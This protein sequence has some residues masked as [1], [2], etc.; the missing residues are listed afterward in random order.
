MKNKKSIFLL[1]S[2]L[3]VFCF[4]S[5]AAE[6]KPKFKNIISVDSNHVFFDFSNI[7]KDWVIVTNQT[8]KLI[9]V[10]Y[11]E[12]DEN[13]TIVPPKKYNFMY[14]FHS[15]LQNQDS[16]EGYNKGKC[17]LE[18]V[19]GNLLQYAI[20]EKKNGIVI[21]CLDFEQKEVS[22][23]PKEID[24]WTIDMLFD[25]EYK[26]KFA[27]EEKYT[28]KVHFAYD[29]YEDSIQIQ[30]D[31]LQNPIL[32]YDMCKDF[33]NIHPE[34]KS[35]TKLTDGLYNFVFTKNEENIFVLSEIEDFDWDKLK[36]IAE[37]K[38]THVEYKNRYYQKIN[39]SISD[40]VVQFDARH[41]NF[42]NNNPYGFKNDCYYDDEKNVGYILQWVDSNTCLYDFAPD[43]VYTAGMAIS[44]IQFD[45]L[46]C[47]YPFD[48]HILYHYEGTFSYT[49]ANGGK[50]TV[51]KFSIIF[52]EDTISKKSDSTSNTEAIISYDSSFFKKNNP[53][54]L[55]KNCKYYESKNS[56]KGKVIQ[57]LDEGCLYDFAGGITDFNW[58]SVVYIEIAEAD[59]NKFFDDNYIK[60]YKYLG[61]LTYQTVRGAMNTV[62][63]LKVYFEEKE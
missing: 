5:F 9:E 31:H 4:E 45:S 28:A 26:D 41:P 59:R 57:W 55:D 50:K 15:E 51:P 23:L 56:I 54:G 7:K 24:V 58:S 17:V 48:E 27:R 38:K 52:N 60:Y 3:F 61:V 21:N 8:E 37:L 46:I 10:T 47:S 39:S 19:N 42:M 35:L 34:I 14:I 25:K 63:K 29:S 6:T 30:D 11:L 62:P 12:I 36:Q 53:Y 2:Y 1:V 33:I 44:L 43:T 49:T 16:V 13:A 18:F 20:S 32:N 22:L 40:T